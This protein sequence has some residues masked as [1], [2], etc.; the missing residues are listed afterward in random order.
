VD[1]HTPRDR[2]GSFEPQFLKK[3]Q[4]RLTQMDD[5]I[6]TLYA[7]GLSTREIVAAF[8]EMVDADLAS[9][10]PIDFAVVDSKLDQFAYDL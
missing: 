8:K 2:D 3:G 5:Q 1:I 10:L 9:Q 4:T 7:K 6:L